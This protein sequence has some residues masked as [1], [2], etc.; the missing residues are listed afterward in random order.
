MAIYFREF[1]ESIG[2][3]TKSYSRHRPSLA[4]EG[5]IPANRMLQRNDQGA[6]GWNELVLLENQLARVY[7]IPRDDDFTL[8]MLTTCSH[9]PE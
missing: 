3:S 4:V 2:D 8:S 9:N 1:A 6:G 5:L 7:A